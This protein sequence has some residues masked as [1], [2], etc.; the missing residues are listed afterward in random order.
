MLSPK[1][2]ESNLNSTQF[3]AENLQTNMNEHVILNIPNQ[4]T[5]FLNAENKPYGTIFRR[6]FLQCSIY[7]P[8]WVTFNLLYIVIHFLNQSIIRTVFQKHHTVYFYYLLVLGVVVLVQKEAGIGH[9]QIL[10]TFTITDC[11]LW[12]RV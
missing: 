2:E 8:V 11:M 1:S 4:P 3:L 12:M 10:N 9:P 5:D 6:I 7:K